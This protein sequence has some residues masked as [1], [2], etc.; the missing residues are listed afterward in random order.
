MKNYNYFEAVLADVKEVIWSG[1]Y[2]LTGD[3]DEL[4]EELHDSLWAEDSVTGNGSGSYTFN[5]YEAEEN[6]AHNWGLLAEALEEFGY[7]GENVIERGAEWADSLIRC[8]LLGSA[9]SA[10][11][12]ELA[13]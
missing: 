3:R 11:L 2:D 13:E 9:I 12:D 6:I 10:A 8:Y 7:T 1:G 4:A 5:R